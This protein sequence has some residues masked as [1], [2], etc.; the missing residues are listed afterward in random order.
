[1]IV[2]KSP[3]TREDFKE[4]TSAL[5]SAT[6]TL[7][8]P[9][10]TEKDDYEPI[11]QHFMAVDDQTNEV[12]GWLSCAKK[13]RGWLDV[14]LGWLPLANIKALVNVGKNG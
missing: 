2:I 9:K 4:S 7:G 8:Q 13:S 14:H 3:V 12:V 1:M 5:R 11:S 10:G 6:Q